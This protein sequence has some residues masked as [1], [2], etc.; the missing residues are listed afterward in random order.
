MARAVLMVQARALM[1][2]ERYAEAA[3]VLINQYLYYETYEALTY[4]PRAYVGL[5]YFAMELNHD[6]MRW[7]GNVM[8]DPCARRPSD[9]DSATKQRECMRSRLLQ[10]DA[11]HA[12]SLANPSPSAQ[13]YSHGG[14]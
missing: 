1:S 9:G 11:R 13:C 6:A 12:G 2:A 10:R 4:H 7:R 8:Q 14:V 3:D 5:C